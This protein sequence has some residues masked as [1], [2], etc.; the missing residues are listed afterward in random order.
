MSYV[1]DQCA[2]LYALE[3]PMES[4]PLVTIRCIQQKIF[5]GKIYRLRGVI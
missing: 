5:E 3:Y 2:N 4:I 1:E